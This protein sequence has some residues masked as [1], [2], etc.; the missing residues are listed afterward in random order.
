VAALTIQLADRLGGLSAG[1]GLRG[2]LPSEHSQI[3]TTAAAV[4]LIQPS[5]RQSSPGATPGKNT[6][7]KSEPEDGETSTGRAH[8]D[9][10]CPPPWRRKAAHG[11][12]EKESRR[13]RANS[14]GCRGISCVHGLDHTRAGTNAAAWTS[15]CGRNGA[16]LRSARVEHRDRQP[17]SRS[18]VSFPRPVPIR[19]PELCAQHGSLT[20]TNQ[21]QRPNLTLLES[22]I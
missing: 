21:E 22:P 3:D 11:A 4:S 6:V 9:V 12:A 2:R 16:N 13:T 7:A 17:V 20:D 10:H 1:A 14:P 5:C 15:I 8:P 18:R 19:G